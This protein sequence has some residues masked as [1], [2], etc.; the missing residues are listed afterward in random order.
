MK[1]FRDLVLSEPII[2]ALSDEGY[3]N[4]T[5]VQTAAIPHLMAGRDLLATAQTGTGKTAAFGLPMLELLAKKNGPRNQGI[6]GLILSPTRELA[7]QI[8]DSLKRYGRYLSLKTAA[9]L[10]GVSISAQ[11]RALQN[12]PD[13]LVATPGRLLDLL[14]QG[15]LR[16][17]RVEM[18]VLDEAD[19]MLDMGFL[20]DVRKVLSKIPARRQTALFSATMPTSIVELATSMLVK[21]IKVE[22]V[23]PA[24]VSR[25]IEQLVLFVEEEN[26]RELIT[27]ILRENDIARV[28]VFT[29]TKHRANHLSRLLVSNGISS[30]AIHSNKSQNARQRA[31]ASFAK[32]EVRALVATDI[33]ARGIDVD[34]ITHVIN[35]EL[36][37]D[38]ENYVHRIGRTA[39]AGELG[40]AIS[41]CGV[42][43][44]PYLQDIERLTQCKLTEVEAHPF[45][46]SSVA[47]LRNRKGLPK[48]VRGGRSRPQSNHN[49]SKG[50]TAHPAAERQSNSRQT[51]NWR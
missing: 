44:I 11:K 39:R 35:F 49:R 46:S 23:R 37:E 33:M 7:L 16:L 27:D 9:I 40:T 15:A 3:S 6:R 19:R 32:G 36:P 25:S 21:P 10:G 17:D 48:P 28:L 13:I 8:E 18:F 14:G 30:D 2:R 38:P 12:V 43:E 31:L 51:S 1:L 5:P 34:G 50:R 22:T 24:T 29:R 45:H 26:K 47:A 20:P 41:L 42:T 4:P